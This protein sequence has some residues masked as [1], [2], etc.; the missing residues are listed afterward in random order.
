MLCSSYARPTHIFYWR[1][2]CMHLSSSKCFSLVHE[3]AQTIV[4]IFKRSTQ[5]KT[6]VY[7]LKRFFS[8]MVVRIRETICTTLLCDCLQSFRII[9]KLYPL[10]LRDIEFKFNNYAVL[11]RFMWSSKSDQNVCHTRILF[12]CDIYTN[13]PCYG[14]YIFLEILLILDFFFSFLLNK[15]A[16]KPHNSY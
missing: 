3:W 8:R 1:R 6:H 10:D 13:E 14:S 9:W 15:L 5:R 16:I 7:T 11:K 12:S 4:N 2:L